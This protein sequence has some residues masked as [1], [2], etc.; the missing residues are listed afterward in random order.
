MPRHKTSM[1][2]SALLTITEAVP[3][4]S[5]P[6]YRLNRLEYKNPD[7]T[8]VDCLTKTH[9]VEFDFAK[10]WAE[11]VGQAEYYSMVTGKRGMVILIIE[12]PEEM[13]YLKKIIALSKIHNFDMDFVIPENISCKKLK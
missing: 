4:S 2:K 11:G 6:R 8:R 13:K 7:K 3:L 5:A 10:K 9:A 12:K 1:S